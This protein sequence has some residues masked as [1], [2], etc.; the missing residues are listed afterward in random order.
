MDFKQL[1]Y[2]VTV[3]EELHVGKAALRLHIAQPALSQQIQHLESQLQVTLFSRE[4]RRCCRK[5]NS[6]FRR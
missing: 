6:P 2:F 4:K 3:A 1:R 5:P